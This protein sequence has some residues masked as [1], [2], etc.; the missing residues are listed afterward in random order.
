GLSALAA[1]AHKGEAIKFVGRLASGLYALVLIQHVAQ[2]H[3]RRTA[4]L[5]AIVLGAGLSALLGIGEALGLRPIQPL[6]AVFKLAP[7]PVGG[8]LR[9]SASFQYA[10]IASM[11][12]EL[13]CPLAVVLAATSRRRGARVLATII[14]ALCAVVVALTITRAG[15]VAL[16]VALV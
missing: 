11:F 10:T 14:A 6:L 5:W 12:F 9:V 4:L 8:D 16:G 1:P 3:S 2:S 7:T 15:V 13:V